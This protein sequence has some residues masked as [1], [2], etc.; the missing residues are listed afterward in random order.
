[1]K[2]SIVKLSVVLFTMLFICVNVAAQTDT[3]S[4]VKQLFTEAQ[5]Q[6]SDSNYVKTIELCNQ[7]LEINDS[8]VGVEMLLS[9]VYDDIKKPDLELYHLNKAVKLNSHPYI[10]WRLGELYYKL[11]NYSEAL[12]F[13]DNYSN[14][15]YISEKKRL[16]LACK[17]ASCIFNIQSL[18]DYSA[19]KDVT[20]TKDVYWPKPSTDGKRLVFIQQN[21]NDDENQDSFISNTDSLDAEIYNH[22][23][24]PDFSE[25]G[26]IKVPVNKEIVFFTGH[27]REDG[28]GN[29]DIYFSRF[30]DGKWTTPV[31]A[32]SSLNSEKSDSQPFFSD[33]EKYL[34]FSS[35]RS[36]GEGERDIWR[37]KL[38]GFA[39]DGSPKWKSPENLSSINGLGNEIS[40]FYYSKTRQLYFASDSYLGMGGYD[41]YEATVA[42]S[43]SVGEFIN[44]GYPINTKTDELGLVVNIISD[45]AFFTSART[46]GEGLE[47][48][49]FNL[50]RGLHT[51]PNFYVHFKAIN[52]NSK[53][54]VQTNIEIVELNNTAAEKELESLNENGELLL[55]LKA[56][57]NYTFNISEQGF[58]FY[59]Q[60]VALGKSN[61][62]SN[63]LEFN[64]ELEPIEIGTEVNL[65]SIFYETNSYAILPGSKSELN[66]LI[67]FLNNNKGVKLEIQGHTD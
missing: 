26:N 41:L 43:G 67:L 31:N 48:F 60:T 5:Q 40:P 33:D 32:G 66:R 24:K 51:Q 1:M 62:I 36:G 47:I 38:I 12:I 27:N 53:L 7:I 50:T 54:P 3:D 20:N 34:Y 8:L 49:A 18:K 55:C 44:L 61:S 19:D 59:S 65:Y 63:P 10:K 46:K 57:R 13:Y 6:Y 30:V 2:N 52:R 29:D 58:M 37:A 22:L 64:I 9:Y 16:T 45:T 56:N 25:D 42:E 28:F 15:K 17:R 14:Y 21:G 11:G 4:D 35:N 39:D 23:N